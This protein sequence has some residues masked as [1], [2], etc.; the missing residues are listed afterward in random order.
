MSAALYRLGQWCFR[1]RRYVA[2]GWVLVI[3]VLAVVAVSV[4]QPTSNSDHHPRTESQQALNLLDQKFPG[5]GGAQAQVVFSVPAPESLTDAS[6][7]QAVEA[8]LAELAKL[9]QVVGVTDP[10]QSGTVSKNG[11]IAYAVVAYPVAVADV[12]TRPRPRF[13]PR[14]ARP[15]RRGSTSTSAGQVAQATT[16]TD[17]ELIGIVI[18]FFVLLIGFGSVIAGLLP[19]SR[20]LP[21]WG[22]PT[23]P[24]W[25]SPGW[26]ASPAPP[27]SWPP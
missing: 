24:C 21:G 15:R 22:S 12:T 3:V 1:R 2:A 19:W 23:S 17:T 16:K 8:T 14:A 11:R 4:K 27:R 7:R 6:D 9:P 10:Y 5:T 13:S 20:P 18:A 25:P 26:S